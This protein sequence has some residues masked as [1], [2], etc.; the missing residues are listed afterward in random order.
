[1][2]IGNMDTE[3]TTKEMSVE[4]ALKRG[5]EIKLKYDLEWNQ[6][7]VSV[8]LDNVFDNAF[9]TSIEAAMHEIPQLIQ[10]LHEWT[11]K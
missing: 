1:M 7:D 9:A 5:Y 6:I 4:E 3:R 8:S 2:E 10:N 11:G